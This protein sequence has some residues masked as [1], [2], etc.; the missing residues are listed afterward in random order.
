MFDKS[1]VFVR[2]GEIFGNYSEFSNS[3]NEVQKLI[4][5]GEVDME[6][7]ATV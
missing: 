5:A 3:S 4:D 7:M 1:E 6:L 2:N